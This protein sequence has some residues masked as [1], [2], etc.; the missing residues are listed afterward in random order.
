[1]V[2]PNQMHHKGLFVRSEHPDPKES[3]LVEV[4]TE[5]AVETL[6]GVDLFNDEIHTFEEVIFQLIKAIACTRG[7][8]ED[9]SWI[10]HLEGKAR[11]YEG[12][13]ESCLRVCG[14]LNE[15]GLVTEIRG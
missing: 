14:V 2:D 3:T 10:V 7:K 9:L 13:F 8:A 12:D 6:W 4:A 11:V 1:M 15:I 5:E